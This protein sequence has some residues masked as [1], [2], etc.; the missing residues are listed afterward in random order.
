MAFIGPEVEVI[1]V[2]EY[3]NDA[4]GSDTNSA[5]IIC[6]K[7]W[8]VTSWN[9]SDILLFFNFNY[10]SQHV[11]TIISQLHSTPTSC[12]SSKFLTFHSVKQIF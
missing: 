9:Q 8:I 6:C 10:Q 7:Q 2:L 3:V 5:D 1:D 12:L 11:D 4:E